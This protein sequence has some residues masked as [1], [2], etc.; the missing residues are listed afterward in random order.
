MSKVTTYLVFCKKALD[1]SKDHWLGKRVL[2]R[3][4]FPIRDYRCKLPDLLSI[5]R[6]GG[7]RHAMGHAKGHIVVLKHSI[8]IMAEYS[9]VEFSIT[10]EF[11]AF[12]VVIF[13]YFSCQKYQFFRNQKVQN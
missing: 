13:L 9:D 11:Y 7:P 4:Q 2:Q 6:F 5:G 1:S 10:L 8:K 3:Q 12:L